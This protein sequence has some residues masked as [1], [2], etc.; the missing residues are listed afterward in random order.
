MNDKLRHLL[1]R[2][3]ARFEVITHPEIYTA[4]E[5]A[6]ACGITGRQLAKVVMVRDGEWFGLAVVPAAAYVDFDELR[7]LTGRP[8]LTLAREQELAS[9]FPDC[10]PGAMPP[11][12]RLYGLS[13]FLD[14][15]LVQEP[16]F[17]FEGGT[18]REEVRMAMDEPRVHRDTRACTRAPDRCADARARRAPRLRRNGSGAPR[19]RAACGPG[20]PSRHRLPLPPSR[21]RRGAAFDPGPLTELCA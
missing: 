17:V 8:D 1:R 16:E 14:I 11:F 19:L 15:S 5:R 9:L 12:G 3:K 20:A 21:A 4:Q 6:A 7:M 13:V 18:H 2:R 10:E